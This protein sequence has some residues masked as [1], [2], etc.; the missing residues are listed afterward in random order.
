MSRKKPCLTRL[1]YSW[2]Q[3]SELRD[4]LREALGARAGHTLR[5]H[6]REISQIRSGPPFDSTWRHNTPSRLFSEK[7]IF[8]VLFYK[9]TS[10]IL[11]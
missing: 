8:V 3:L 5:A 4:P 6:W 10:Y 1:S 2:T 11:Y 7:F 9:Y